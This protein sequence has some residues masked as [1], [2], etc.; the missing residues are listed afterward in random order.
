MCIRDRPYSDSDSESDEEYR[1][2][3]SRV[4]ISNPTIGSSTVWVG[5]RI[6]V[7]GH[8][9]A[10]HYDPTPD[11][12]SDDDEQIFGW[13]MSTQQKKQ[14]SPMKKCVFVEPEV[15]DLSQSD[16]GTL[17]DIDTRSNYGSAEIITA[18]DIRAGVCLTYGISIAPGQT[19]VTSGAFVMSA[20]H[21]RLITTVPS[22][23][24]T[25]MSLD[26]DISPLTL[27]LIHI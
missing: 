6:V 8:R 12:D 17:I 21:R 16:E 18:D 3:H 10:S 25:V 14:N 5:Q 1:P 20:E 27:S 11:S 22:A 9:Q 2:N 24:Q 13:A 23:S 4:P 19:S 7:S 15:I 26:E